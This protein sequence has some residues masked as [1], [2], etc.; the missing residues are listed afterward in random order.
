KNPLATAGRDLYCLKRDELSQY[1]KPGYIIQEAVEDIDLIEGR[2]YTIRA[3][4]LVANNAVYLFPDAVVVIHGKLY[5]PSDR[6]PEAQF[7]HEGYNKPGSPV[8]MRR[9]S[10]LTNYGVIHENL[11]ITVA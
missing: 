1:F 11:K 4:V 7:L 8:E 9:F 3:Y 2:K 10:T 6:S 5:D